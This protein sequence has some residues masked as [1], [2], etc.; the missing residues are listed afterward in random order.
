[1]SDVS[2]LIKAMQKASKV[3][4][5]ETVDLV[6]GTVKSIS[7]LKIK[8]DKLELTET[9]LIVGALCKLVKIKISDEIPQVTLWRGLKVGDE[10]YMLR[11]DKG[12]KYYVLQRKEGVV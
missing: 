2:R 12:Q 9:F 11:V 10:V 8:V 5:N 1:M 7:P 4:E 6:V 3:P